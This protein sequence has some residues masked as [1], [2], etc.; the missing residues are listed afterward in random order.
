MMPELWNAIREAL[1]PALL[2]LAGVGYAPAEPARHMPHLEAPARIGTI[3]AI[4]VRIGMGDRSARIVITA[5]PNRADPTP[6][7]QRRLPQRPRL[8]LPALDA[9]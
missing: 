8:V 2:S 3:A 5:E 4:D 7:P 9:L 1:V 6:A